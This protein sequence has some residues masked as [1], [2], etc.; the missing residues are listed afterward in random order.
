VLA[1]LTFR[2]RGR[3]SGVEANWSLWQLWTVRD[4]RFVRGQGFTDRDAALEAVRLSE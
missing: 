4:G 1:T 2:G 3:Q